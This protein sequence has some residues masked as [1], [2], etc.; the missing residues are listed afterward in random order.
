MKCN[1]AERCILHQYNLEIQHSTTT[2]LKLWQSSYYFYTLTFFNGPVHVAAG[3]IQHDLSPACTWCRR[4]CMAG[5]RAILSFNPKASFMGYVVCD[6]PSMYG[7][8]K[9]CLLHCIYV[10]I[11]VVC[12]CAIWI[13]HVYHCPQTP[14]RSLS[15]PLHLNLFACGFVPCSNSAV[16]LSCSHS[17]WDHGHISPSW[18]GLGLCHFC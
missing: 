8:K 11:C 4:G 16:A 2:A 9:T 13:P 17:F 15:H 6:T 14:G 1:H 3:H 7:S 12:A 10:N 5:G 18:L